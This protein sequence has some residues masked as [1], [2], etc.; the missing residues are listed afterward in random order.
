[1][2]RTFLACLLVCLVLAPAWAQPAPPA[3]PAP[4]PALPAPGPA[5]PAPVTTPPQQGMPLT[6]E[7]AVATAIAANPSLQAARESVDI[8]RDQLS[9][10]R[11]QKGPSVG[12]SVVYTRVDRVPSISTFVPSPT[13]P[14]GFEL[15]TFSLG[16]E[17]NVDAQTTFGLPVYSGGALS[18]GIRAARHGVVAAKAAAARSEQQVA[19]A[20]R[21]AYYGVLTAMDA[22]T[23]ARQALAAA[24]EQLRVARAFVQAG[25]APQFD[26]L[27]AEARTAEARQQVTL[28]ANGE[29]IARAALNNAMGVPQEWTFNLTTPL[30]REPTAKDLEQLQQAALAARPDLAQFRANEQALRQGI[31]AA[32][33][34]RLPSVG[35]S[36]TLSAPVNETTFAVGGWTL[37]IAANFNLFDSG[38]TRARIRESQDRLQQIQ[39][40]TN[41]LRQAV[42]FEV[43]QAYLNLNT[44]QEQLVTAAAELRAAD[45]ALR[46]AQVRY[47]AGISTT[48]EVIDAQVARQSAANSYNAATYNYNL[49]LAQLDLALG[50]QVAPGAAPITVPPTKER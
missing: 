14:L 36:W 33:A 16:K 39:A 43:K 30:R 22:T 6:L 35:L 9:G 8:A 20:V 25:T 10:A 50:A 41:Q 12:S 4:G 34:S 45:E 3:S 11:A 31:V 28:G 38:R 37:A 15:R 21:Q 2:F 48:V 42:T 13:S 47:Q 7:Q 26:V 32:R 17:E 44:A 24:E 23:V 40:F 27:R 46:I 5:L 1:M 18:A 19:Y 29:S 49:A